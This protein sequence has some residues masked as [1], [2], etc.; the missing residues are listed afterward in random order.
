MGA[1]TSGTC[2]PT[3]SAGGT[4]EDWGWDIAV[5]GCGNS[6]ITG[7]FESTASF[8]STTLTSQGG[9]DVFV[10]KLSSHPE[11]DTIECEDYLDT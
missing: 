10:A 6:Y 11:I 1:Y 7:H 5:T 3:K 8:G 9:E 2:S 4:G